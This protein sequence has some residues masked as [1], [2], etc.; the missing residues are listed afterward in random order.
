MP[1]NITQ[2]GAMSFRDI[3]NAINEK[4]KNADE[5]ALLDAQKLSDLNRILSSPQYREA[6]TYSP[7]FGVQYD[8]TQEA[9][10]AGLGESKYDKAAYSPDDLQ[11]LNEVRAREQSGVTQILAGLGKGVVLTGTT[12][13]DSTLGTLMGIL[14]VA[15]KGISGEIHSGKDALN[16]FIDNPVSRFLQDVNNKSE[17]LMPNYQTEWE[18][19][20]HWWQKLG[21]ANFIGDHFLKNTGFFVGA[22]LSGITNA[23]LLTKAMQIDKMKNAFKGVTSL[24]GKSLNNTSD[25]L[26]AIKTGDAVMDGAQLTEDLVNAAKT[27]KNQEYFVKFASGIAGSIGESRMEA[28]SGSE[29]DFEAR[30]QLLLQEKQKAIANVDN[31]LLEQHPEWYSY[32]LPS[33]SNPTTK[34]E[35]TSS[36]GLREKERLIRE[37]NSQYD[38]YEQELANERIQYANN[39]FLLNMIITSADNIYQFGDAFTGGFK[40]SRQLAAIKKLSDGTYTGSKIEMAKN[41]G[42]ALGSP[43]FEMTQE[44]LQRGIQIGEERWNAS[45]FND[46][47]GSALDPKALESEIGYFHNLFNAVGDTFTS[48]DE[49]ENGF[50]GAITSLLPMPGGSFWGGISDASKSNK[51]SKILADTLNEFVKDDSKREWL[52]HLSRLNAA[53]RQQEIARLENDRFSFKNAEMDKA[54]SSVI[55]YT[56]AGKFQDFLEILENAYTV[57]ESDIDSIKT[58]AIDKT[59]GKSIYDGMTDEQILEHFTSNKDKV[60]E[61]AKKI[62]DTYNALS[63]LFGEKTDSKTI[64]TLTYLASSVDNREERIKSITQELIDEIN[65]DIETFENTFGYS[66]VSRLRDIHDLKTWFSEE[67]KKELLDYSTGIRTKEAL[68]KAEVAS[69][70]LDRRQ[71]RRQVLQGRKLGNTK[72]IERLEAKKAT[73]DLTAEEEAKLKKAKKVLKDSDRQFTEVRGVIEDLKSFVSSQTEKSKFEQQAS[74]DKLQDLTHLLE[75]REILV[76]VLNQLQDNPSKLEESLSNDIFKSK[77]I[78][79][80]R[81]QEK[82]YNNIKKAKDK[83]TIILENYNNGKISPQRLQQLAEEK[84]DVKLLEEIKNLN[85]LLGLHKRVSGIFVGENNRVYSGDDPIIKNIVTNFKNV[86]SNI[87]S[88]ANDEKDAKNKIDEFINNAIS[89]SNPIVSKIANNIKTALEKQKE[90]TTSASNKE[91][92]NKDKSSKKDNTS[93]ILLKLKNNPNRESE[94]NKMSEEE[95]KNLIIN[96]GLYNQMNVEPDELDSFDKD[97]LINSILDE[98]EYYEEEISETEV[99]EEEIEDEIEENTT[100]ETVE[101][102]ED[103]EEEEDIITVDSDT[104]PILA[105]KRKVITKGSSSDT[106]FDSSM[107]VGNV[108][109][110]KADNYSENTTTVLKKDVKYWTVGQKSSRY[111]I[112]PLANSDERKLVK[113]EGNWEIEKLEKLGAYSFVDSGELSKLMLLAESVG[114]QLPVTFVQLRGQGDARQ[115]SDGKNHLFLAIDWDAVEEINNLSPQD[116]VYKKPDGYFENTF[117]K[118]GIDQKSKMQVIGKFDYDKTSESHKKL[119]DVVQKEIDTIGYINEKGKF[120]QTKF[121]ASSVVT[122]LDWV[123]SGRL[124][125]QNETFDSIE[126]RDLTDIIPRKEDSEELID[127]DGEIQLAL[128]TPRGEAIVG[129][130]LD[131]EVIELNSNRPQSPVTHSDRRLATPW[132]KIREADGRVYYK[133]IRIKKFDSNYTDDDSPIAQRIKQSLTNISKTTDEALIRNNLSILRNYLY[134]PSGKKLFVNTKNETLNRGDESISLK[135]TPEE[136]YEFVKSQGY[137]FTFGLD[138][139]MSLMDTITS[140]IF[141]TDLA[142]L[143]NANASM[144]ISKVIFNED[145]DYSIQPHDDLVNRMLQEVHLGKKGFQAGRGFSAPIKIYGDDTTYIKSDNGTYYIEVDGHREEAKDLKPLQKALIDFMITL[146]TRTDGWYFGGRRGSANTI[147]ILD[148]KIGNKLYYITDSGRI[149]TDEEVKQFKIYIDKK[150]KK[151]KSPLRDKAEAYLNEHLKG[152]SN[153]LPVLTE[154]DLLESKK[155]VIK[156]YMQNNNITEISNSELQKLFK[157]TRSQLK[158]LKDSLT[159][160]DV[161]G[162]TKDGLIIKTVEKTPESPVKIVEEKKEDKRFRSRKKATRESGK[163]GNEG[164]KNVTTLSTE[165]IEE[166]AN[167]VGNLIKKLPQPLQG[168]RTEILRLLP[169]KKSIDGFVEWLNTTLLNEKIKTDNIIKYYNQAFNEDFTVDSTIDNLLKEIKQTLNCG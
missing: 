20:A 49:W 135:A 79:D 118:A 138:P 12:F 27:L 137:I 130:D 74:L 96:T 48:A 143:H 155:E 35:L 10:D 117:F 70:R 89:D 55:T 29:E 119:L 17:E 157:L 87:I 37:I 63:V 133:A 77:N 38:L 68:H 102:E 106:V 123:F 64:N 101:E 69:K 91:T 28:L 46:F 18:K 16:A 98:L 156:S 165:E 53:E 13:F 103:E 144:V 149:L 127:L 61:G 90:N 8:Y 54:I 67:D 41:I 76:D 160:D 75:E 43:V 97:G 105:P 33:E 39:S 147:R 164:I 142:Q 104:N 124:V 71:K 116:K 93:D 158:E 92:S 153:E 40:Q 57:N 44:M 168:L 22:Y 1:N 65:I 88:E 4:F 99:D 167:T 148:H 114:K 15:E 159:D 100:E 125:K 115:N 154:K 131:G 14:N 85:S 24:S 19:N 129:E 145:G 62:H 169:G 3:Q 25:I 111:K 139:K 51:E 31:I 9:V 80:N 146:P 120:T 30:H 107:Q 11:N 56:N 81:Q 45:K 52:F 47:Y 59:T 161:F 82:I 108:K 34:A 163:K 113:R 110:E 140:N 109:S 150:L 134:I 136:L 132:I 151:E 6:M 7:D 122:A 121:A 58:L 23:G 42:E 50:L 26:K 32:T 84:Q 166:M 83:K 60:I 112:E 36:E 86:L 94:L 95:L 73:Q 128:I 66:P 126:Q 78:Y 152:I 72:L 5:A 141:T 21:T 162:V 2:T